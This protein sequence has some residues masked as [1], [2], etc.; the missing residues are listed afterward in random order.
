MDIPRQWPLLAT[1]RAQRCPRA[2]GPTDPGAKRGHDGLALAGTAEE[3][4]G[5]AGVVGRA[6]HLGHQLLG[7]EVL[8]VRRAVPSRSTL[9]VSWMARSAAWKGWGPRR[10]QVPQGGRRARTR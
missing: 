9:K 5:P 4:A 2:C 3:V 10:H 7:S 1:A 6:G 8:Q